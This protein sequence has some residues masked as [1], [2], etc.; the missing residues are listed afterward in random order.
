[1][2]NNMKEHLMKKDKEEL[3]NLLLGAYNQIDFAERRL[4][5]S[6]EMHSQSMGMV[7]KLIDKLK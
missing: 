2:S 4:A 1:M 3:V 6:E 7:K 5:H